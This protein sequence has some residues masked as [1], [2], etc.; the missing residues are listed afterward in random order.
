VQYVAN[1]YRYYLTY[2]MVAMQALAREEARKAAGIG[3]AVGAE[4]QQFTAAG[5]AVGATAR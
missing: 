1:I 3:A 4:G 2:R 5:T